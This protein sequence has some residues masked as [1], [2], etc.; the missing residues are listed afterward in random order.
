L[1]YNFTSEFIVDLKLNFALLATSNQP[2]NIESPFEGAA[3]SATVAPGFT[4]IV[5]TA[6]VPPRVSKLTE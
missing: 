4:L 2:A 1:A 6:G 5:S 3:G